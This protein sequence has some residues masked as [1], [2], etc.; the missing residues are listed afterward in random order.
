MC[1]SSCLSLTRQKARTTL[2][3]GVTTA[4]AFSSSQDGKFQPEHIEVENKVYKG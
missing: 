3:F 2:Q 4:C 1:Y